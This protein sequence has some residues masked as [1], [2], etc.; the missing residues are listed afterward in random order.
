MHPRALGWRLWQGGTGQ[1][2]ARCPDRLCRVLRELQERE[3]ALQL[4]RELEEKKKVRAVW[5]PRT[6]TAA[7][8]RWGEVRG[9][10]LT[11]CPLPPASQEEQ[12]RLAEQRLQEEQEKKA[13]EAAAASKALNVTVDVQVR[14]TRQRGCGCERP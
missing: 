4:Q 12:Q 14:G 11:R 2:P 5:A 3:K 8:W 9:Q 13:R 6:L 10:V 1:G 7:G